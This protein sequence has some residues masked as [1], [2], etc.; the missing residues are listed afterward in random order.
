[1]R[2]NAWLR[3]N[4]VFELRSCVLTFV[5]TQTAGILASLNTF[6]LNSAHVRG[7]VEGVVRRLRTIKF[8][9]EA[10]SGTAPVIFAEI[11]EK[12]EAFATANEL[13]TRI[14]R[15]FAELNR[16]RTK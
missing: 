15:N 14:F 11:P 2:R 8:I 13:E 12:I 5:L 7:I 9:W 10:N 6:Y 16:V 4:F 3:S 1:M